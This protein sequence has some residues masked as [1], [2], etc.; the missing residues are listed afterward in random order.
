MNNVDAAVEKRLYL[1]NKRSQQLIMLFLLGNTIF[2]LLYINAMNVS[3]RLGF[4]VML[5]IFLSLFV[6]L[7]AV[8][9]KVYDLRWGY[10]GI[11]LGIFQF[12]RMLWIPAEII[13]QTRLIL[14]ILLI[15]TGIIALVASITCI[16]RSQERQQYIVE[17]GVDDALM[18]R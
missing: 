8:R 10:A 16:Q 7:M 15:A 2:T 11:A 1:E 6:F 3:V 4:F 18:Q 9:Q 17:H 12:A 5:N 14:Q 13:D